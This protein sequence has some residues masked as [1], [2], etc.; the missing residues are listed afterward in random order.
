[1]EKVVINVK[2]RFDLGVKL[3]L[4][5]RI[6]QGYSCGA[7][8]REYLQLLYFW[9]GLK[10]PGSNKAGAEN[11]VASFRDMVAKEKDRETQQM[12]PIP[13]N[14]AGYIQNGSHRLAT[15]LALHKTPIFCLVNG[16]QN[17]N[18]LY[19]KKFNGGRGYVPESLRLKMLLRNFQSLDKKIKVA[20][21]FPRAM[22]KDEGV[23]AEEIIKDNIV[24]DESYDISEKQL[25]Y[26]I[27]NL[28]P[29]ERWLDFSRGGAGIKSKKNSIIRKGS[30]QRIRFIVYFEEPTL[31]SEEKKT[32]IRNY[33][34]IEK[35]SIHISDNKIDAFSSVCA[36]FSIRNSPF[37]VNKISYQSQVLRYLNDRVHE[38]SGSIQN[39]YNIML[40]GS[41]PLD[42]FGVRA[43]NDIDFISWADG[44][45][46]RGYSQHNP[47]S[48]FYSDNLI[49]FIDGLD[50][51]LFFFG[52]PV[53][54]LSCVMEY[55]RCRSEKKDIKDL[56]LIKSWINK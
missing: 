29:G 21:I 26:I 35:S 40:V 5:K 11:F 2:D 41:A 34:K 4:A 28:Y 39:L 24:W 56:R 12:P 1:M 27:M 53:G 42:I 38:I 17:Y 49:D 22:A 30:G 50:N 46:L 36:L 45:A 19:F 16:C 55:K 7:L 44:V 13:V 14:Q 3:K 10:E 47:Y 9:N 6:S 25:E 54:K 31:S 23:Y 51:K 18:Y 33:Y 37:E 32:I 52:I 43:A 8:T 20:V 15:A 48:F